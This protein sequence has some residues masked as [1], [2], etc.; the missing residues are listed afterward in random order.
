[1]SLAHL[2]R[3]VAQLPTL[4][5]VYAL[6]AG[7]SSLHVAYVGIAENLRARVNQH[8]VMRNSSATAGL[9]A[10]RLDPDAIREVRWWTAPE[11]VADAAALQA[12]EAIAHG[13]LA[14]AM[15]SRGGT[16]GAA[17]TRMGDDAFAHRMRALFTG[18]PSGRVVVPTLQDAL[19]RIDLLERRMAE[20]EALIGRG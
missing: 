1:M 8:L 7:S 15:R 20:L 9:P 18:E 17:K 4:P 19:D 12:A 11:F 13:E 14:P 5:A 10:V 3:V 6:Y 2:T 16:T